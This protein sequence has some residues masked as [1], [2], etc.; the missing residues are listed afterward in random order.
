[1]AT[2]LIW[3]EPSGRV[4][5]E[6]NSN[7]P[8]WRVLQFVFV[9]QT[10]TVQYSDKGYATKKAAF[11]AAKLACKKLGIPIM[12]GEMREN[13]EREFLALQESLKQTKGLM[14]RAAKRNLSED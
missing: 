10:G 1:M 4:I 7:A 13:G 2:M 8:Y 5:V 12:R 14:A 6:W 11:A 3:S 9:D